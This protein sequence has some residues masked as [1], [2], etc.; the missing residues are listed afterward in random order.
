MASELL[1]VISNYPANSDTRS[2]ADFCKGYTCSSGNKY[3]VF[4]WVTV[5]PWQWHSLTTDQGP[6]A[7]TRD[8]KADDREGK[9]GQGAVLMA[10][11][12]RI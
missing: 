11:P 1:L 12:Y 9:P 8:G 4:P 6:E 7:V 3:C 5:S 10:G 2:G